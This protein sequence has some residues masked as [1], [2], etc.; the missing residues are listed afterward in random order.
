MQSRRY[1][2]YAVDRPL[3]AIVFWEETPIRRVHGRCQVLAEGGLGASLPDELYVGEVVRLEMPPLTRIYACVRDTR[4][5]QHGFEFLY[6]ND[7]QRRAIRRLCDAS[8]PTGN[9]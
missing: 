9:A 1:A 2:R 6:L 8:A 7:L 3:T 5:T 4:G